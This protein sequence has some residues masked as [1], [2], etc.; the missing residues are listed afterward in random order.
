MEFLT[1]FVVVVVIVGALIIYFNIRVLQH[2][3]KALKANEEKAMEQKLERA[4]NPVQ[5]AAVQVQ[6]ETSVGQ[7]EA[8]SEDSRPIQNALLRAKRPAGQMKMSDGDYRSALRQQLLGDSAE[9]EKE[10]NTPDEQESVNNDDFYRS[11]LRSM[12]DKRD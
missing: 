11:A 2:E 6:P 1:I 8:P 9:T 5:P 12:Q 7:T 3:E 4:E 10:L